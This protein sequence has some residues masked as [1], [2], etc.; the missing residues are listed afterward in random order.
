MT[1]R[2]ARVW[3]QPVW[4]S[5]THEY[6]SEAPYLEEAVNPGSRDAHR[7]SGQVGALDRPRG[8][9]ECALVPDAPSQ[10][11]WETLGKLTLKKKCPQNAIAVLKGLR[12]IW[13]LH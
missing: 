13:A 6:L 1:G 4:R 2:W 5:R 7:L 11:R 10:L 8:R 12:V 3:A 9:A